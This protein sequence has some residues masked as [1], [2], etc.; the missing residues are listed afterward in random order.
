MAGRINPALLLGISTDFIYS[1]SRLSSHVLAN[2]HSTNINTYICYILI[3]ILCLAMASLDLSGKLH[4]FA[5]FYFQV[6]LGS[7]GKK[8]VEEVH[9]SFF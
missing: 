8:F 9:T 2:V 7:D 4:P 5:N 1:I 3:L 6:R